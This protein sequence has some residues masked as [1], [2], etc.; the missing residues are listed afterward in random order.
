MA[1]LA[2]SRQWI[3]ALVLAVLAQIAGAQE[4]TPDEL[5]QKGLSHFN[6]GDY[7]DAARSFSTLVDRFGNER[8][9]T[10]QLESVF[11]ALGCS[12]YNLGT[13]PEAVRTLE[14]YLK[15]YPKARF[16]DEVLFR[17]GA[18]Q[19]SA[20]DYGKAVTAYQRL[21]TEQPYSPFAEDAAF[22]I[23]IC[24]L[25]QESAAKSAEAFA[26][27]L[28][29]Y[30][31][32]DLVAQAL[33]F[34]ARALFEAGKLE[35]AV[36]TLEKLENR[37]R[38]LEH[39]VYSNFLAIEIGD[40]A[41]DNTDYELALRAYR[42]VRTRESL[43]R[44]QGGFVQDL[45][46]AL[47][48]VAAPGALTQDVKARFRQ[49]RRLRTS[50]AQAKELLQRLESSPNYDDSLFHRIGRCFMSIDRL[51]EART[52]FMRV[53]EEA[54]DDKVREAAHFD[55]ILVLSRMRQFDDLILEAD[56]Y[57]ADYEPTEIQP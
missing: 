53:V 13:F 2:F 4:E 40:A 24:L 56:R 8:S 43:L 27:F 46:A 50:L 35:E 31:K 49:E 21:V 5:F 57:L 11:Y 17:L 6:T 9:L 42:R 33:T 14:E 51:W 25:A 18:A 26:G 23:G 44:L 16:S 37:G 12:Y 22:Q 10:N 41:F 32:S 39:L 38:R 36:A 30:P 48:E 19:Q 1:R 55:L 3:P 20:E 15:R 54:T 28:Q 29:A 7:A 45:G 52:A 47:Q 34:Q